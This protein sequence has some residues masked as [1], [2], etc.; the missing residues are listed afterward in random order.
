MSTFKKL[1]LDTFPKYLL[2]LEQAKTYHFSAIFAPKCGFKTALKSFD[3]KID[4]KGLYIFIDPALPT[5]EK[6]IYTGISQNVI[7]RLYQHARS[8]NHY[9]GNLAYKI[10][11]EEIQH[12]K[13][14]DDLK[15]LSIGRDKILSLNF[16]F[17][18]IENP[19]ERYLFEVFVSMNYDT[20]Y[21]SFETH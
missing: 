20:K 12:S 11:K 4:F 14:R 18:A 21:N 9:S 17:I 7:A 6:V 3:L 1:A 5:N 2:Q 19:I 13:S 8:N 10:T 15:D 16:K